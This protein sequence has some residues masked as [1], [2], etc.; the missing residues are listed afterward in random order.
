MNDSEFQ[1]FIRESNNYLTAKIARAREEFHIGEFERYEY[2]LP[3]AR[4][5][6]SDQGVSKVE[7]RIITVGSISTISN[8]WR[9][10]WANPHFDDV[11][12]NEIVRVRVF[13][14]KNNILKLTE[15][16]WPADEAD[17]W[18]MTAVSARLLEANAA[19]RSPSES[20]FLFLLLTH[21]RWI[22]DVDST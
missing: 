21:L 20:G 10:A 15:G 6:W 16:K 9:W 4:F 5:W 1:D 13:G 17:G 2:D 7:A 22:T 12:M 18:E 19:Y 8:T 14:E 3:S 11:E